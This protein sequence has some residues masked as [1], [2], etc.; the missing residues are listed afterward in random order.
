M[1]TFDIH[2]H[3]HY[4]GEEIFHFIMVASYYK[5]L[6]TVYTI[7]ECICSDN[8]IKVNILLFLKLF[9]DLIN[10]ATMH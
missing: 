9:S 4:L 6:R 2:I 5:S 3:K 7:Q 8:L 10:M 1:K